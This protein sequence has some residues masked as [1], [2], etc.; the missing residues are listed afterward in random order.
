MISHIPIFMHGKINIFI[1]M[2]N[3]DTYTIKHL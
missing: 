1:L 3:I 2:V